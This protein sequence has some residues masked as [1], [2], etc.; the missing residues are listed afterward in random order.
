[1]QSF[2]LCEKV[3]LFLRNVN[4]LNQ[5]SYFFLLYGLWESNFDALKQTFG[6]ISIQVL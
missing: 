4:L 2:F 1:M 5:W 3:Q 6:S